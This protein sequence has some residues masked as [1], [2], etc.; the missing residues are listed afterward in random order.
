[1]PQRKSL[2]RK[3][4]RPRRRKQIGQYT[5]HSLFSI[6]WYIDSVWAN[7]RMHVVVRAGT[8]LKRKWFKSS[9]TPAACFNKDIKHFEA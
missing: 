1:M 8:D 3:T 7:E 5:A 6:Q 4:P 2:K 9:N